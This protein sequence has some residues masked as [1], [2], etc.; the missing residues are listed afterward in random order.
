MIT[1]ELPKTL[2]THLRDVVQNKYDGN[3]QTAITTFLMLDEKYGWEEQLV[4]DIKSVRSE[5]RKKGGIKAKTIDET[6]KRYREGSG[7][8]A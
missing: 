5:V 3:M 2:E 7:S 1:I 6:I 4:Q 8:D